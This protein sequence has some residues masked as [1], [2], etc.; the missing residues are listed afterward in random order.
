MAVPTV[1][2]TD[3]G[4]RGWEVDREL[5]LHPDREVAIGGV[6]RRLSSTRTGFTGGVRWGVSS[7]IVASIRGVR[8]WVDLT[9]GVDCVPVPHD[10]G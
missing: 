8:I 10:A 6:V 9:E 2:E 5:L 3:D 4:E 7:T 1:G